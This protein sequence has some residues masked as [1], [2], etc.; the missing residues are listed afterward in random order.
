VHFK[1]PPGHPG[2][3]FDTH[4]PR[5]TPRRS[6]VVNGSFRCLSRWPFADEDLAIDASSS[7]GA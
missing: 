4:R 6:R 7:R 1:Y 5:H 2:H 3:V